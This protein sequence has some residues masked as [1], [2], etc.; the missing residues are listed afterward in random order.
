MA[1]IL[2]LCL[3]VSYVYCATPINGNGN[4]NQIF[5]ITSFPGDVNLSLVNMATVNNNALYV[6]SPT[7]NVQGEAWVATPVPVKSF[8]TTFEFSMTQG[9]DYPIFV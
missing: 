3:F 1:Y 5:N 8:Y 7:P 9:T 6:S 2:F 4:C